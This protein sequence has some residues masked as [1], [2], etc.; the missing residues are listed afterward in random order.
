MNRLPLLAQ[1]VHESRIA[2]IGWSVAL[3]TICLVYLPFYASLADNSGLQ[4]MIARLPRSVVRTIG[5]DQITSG[6]GYA[7]ATVLGLIGF[8]LGTIAAISWGAHAIGEDE[9]SG[10]L[11]LTVAHAVSRRRIVLERAASVAVRMGALAVV[12]FVAI[13]AVNGPAT[14]GL[15]AGN[16]AAGVAAWWGVTTLSG[17]AAVL[18][19]AITG[20]RVGAVGAGAGL[21]VTGYGANAL[22]RQSGQV[23]WLSDL[24]P[25]G[26]AFG[27]APV[28]NGWDAAGLALLMGT[29]LLVVAAS[30][31]TFGRRDLHT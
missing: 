8:V 10:S 1:A 30:V 24:T 7:Q 23:S 4:Q 2:I 11:E 20:R 21:A 18:G 25:Y 19:G 17:L 12:F 31:V 13:L 22:A 15:H 6:P 26:W 3:T 9:E 5:Y 16:L 29:G 28:T 14:L 27:S